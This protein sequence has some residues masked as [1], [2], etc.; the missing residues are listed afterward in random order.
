[1]APTGSPHE[2]GHV[3]VDPEGPLC[4]CGAHGC[5]EQY[6][7]R[8]ALLR[9][10]GIDPA[11]GVRGIA[12]LEQRAAAGEKRAVTALR[13][14]GD[15]LGV[16]LAGAVNLFDPEAVVLGGIY[17]SLM[18]WLEG[19][20]DA[21]LTARVV[22]GRWHENGSRLRASSLSGD[23]ARGAAARVVHDVLGNPA[24]FAVR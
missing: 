8:A 18:P 7:G 5:L 19:P 17:R 23:A 24:A 14:A 6:A 12:E 20:A 13:E 15:R 11:M 16:V 4:R 3:V 21:Q 2:I 9:A 10:S 1:M 22:S